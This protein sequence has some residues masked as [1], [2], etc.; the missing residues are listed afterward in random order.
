MGIPDIISSA[1]PGGA[2]H[3]VTAGNDR[4]SSSGWLSPDGHTLIGSAVRLHRSGGRDDDT[5]R[6]GSQSKPNAYTHAYASAF[7]AH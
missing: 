1:A 3:A 5:H 4:R 6:A 2:S 7:S